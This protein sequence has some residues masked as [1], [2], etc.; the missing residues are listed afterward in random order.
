MWGSIYSSFVVIVY[1]EVLFTLLMF[2][3]ILLFQAMK[4]VR[5]CMENPYDEV[6]TPLR[7]MLCVL[8]NLLRC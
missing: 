7:G 8:V 4:E 3:F 1:M 2:C 5:G 6:L